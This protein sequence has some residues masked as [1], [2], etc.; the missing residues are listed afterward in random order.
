M[1]SSDAKQ[2]RQCLFEF[3]VEVITSNRFTLSVD[4]FVVV[5]LQMSCWLLPILIFQQA[6]EIF[7]TKVTLLSRRLAKVIFLLIVLSDFFTEAA[8]FI[9][10]VTLN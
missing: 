4:T 7:N 5:V 3:S 6:L 8:R 9:L 2:D 10:Y 1:Y